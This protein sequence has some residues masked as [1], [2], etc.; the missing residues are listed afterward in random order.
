MGPIRYQVQL[1]ASAAIILLILPTN[2]CIAG[3]AVLLI[4]LPPERSRTRLSRATQNEVSM[5]HRALR[6]LSDMPTV[7]DE[8]DESEDTKIGTLWGALQKAKAVDVTVGA[9]S[10]L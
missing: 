8:E 2:G 5:F 3:G 10:E 9:K 4:S 6:A 7:A 1:V